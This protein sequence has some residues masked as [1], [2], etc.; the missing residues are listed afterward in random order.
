MSAETYVEVYD[1]WSNL[2]GRFATIDSADSIG[3]Y[4]WDVFHVLRGADGYL[5]VGEGAGCSCNSFDSTDGSDFTRVDSWQEA[6]AKAQQWAKE[7]D[8]SV[9]QRTNVV[10]DLIQRLAQERPAPHVELD[11]RNP[12]GGAK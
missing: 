11:I 9:E 6:A 2:H 7:D 4:E 8:W 12:F 10:M 3:G 5:Y 1:S